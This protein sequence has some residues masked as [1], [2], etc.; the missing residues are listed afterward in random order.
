MGFL[1]TSGNEFKP[2]DS[3][4]RL[5]LLLAFAQGLNY[6]FSG[7]IETILA[8]YTDAASIRSDV[9]SAIAAL[10]QRG[11]VVN[12]PDIQTLNAEKV[13][14][15][16]EVCALLYKALVSTG[17]VVNISSQYAVEQ[18]QEQAQIEDSDD[19]E[20]DSKKPRRH[21]NQGIGNGAE[22]CDPGNSRPHGG[23]NDEGDRTVGGKKHRLGL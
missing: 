2:F 18:T 17:E 3:L 16:A 9:R 22:G 20:R 11:V 21:C 12:Y 4:S 13:A 15:R 1:G 10:T 19:T 23:S 6:K 14:T 5:E 8:A 7:S